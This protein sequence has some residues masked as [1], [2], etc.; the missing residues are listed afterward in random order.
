MKIIFCGEFVGM[1]LSEQAK[2]WLGGAATITAWLGAG[3]QTV[4]KAQAQG[5]ANVCLKCPMNTRDHA[6]TAAVAE[7]VR[8]QVEIK[9]KLE[10]RLDGEK[11]LHTCSGCGCVLR[12]KLWL[13]ITRLGLDSSEIEKFDA[14]CWM[15]KEYTP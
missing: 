13:P 11:S 1:N 2:Q 9:N 3:A 4:S 14:S 5:R 10:L 8:K 15:R 12:L 7:A 6:F